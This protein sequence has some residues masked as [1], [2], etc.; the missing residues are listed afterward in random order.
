MPTAPAR[1]ETPEFET[2]MHHN[3]TQPLLA[4]TPQQAGNDPTSHS[5]HSQRVNIGWCNHVRC[6]AHNS[7]R[8]ALANQPTA[9]LN[10]ES[11]NTV[12]QSW[13][14]TDYAPHQPNGQHVNYRHLRSITA[15]R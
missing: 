1:T 3:P 13:R 2:V 9:P 10:G 14:A 12:E 11:T 15:V 5:T 6:N 8:A 4:N 7:S